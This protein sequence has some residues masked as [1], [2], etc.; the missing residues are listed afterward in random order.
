MTKVT[1][2]LC[3]SCQGESFS[4]SPRHWW[5]RI[6]YKSR[7][8]RCDD[9][10]TRIFVRRAKSHTWRS[11]YP[12]T[13]HSSQI[14]VYAPSR[15]RYLRAHRHRSGGRR[16]FDLKVVG[17]RDLTIVI[18][19]LQRGELLLNSLRHYLDLEPAPA[20]IIVIDQTRNHPESVAQELVRFTQASRI[21]WLSLRGRSHPAAMNLGLLYADTRYVVFQDD[22]V[23]P[24]RNL[25]GAFVTSIRELSRA[26]AGAFIA[27]QV[28]NVGEH[29]V[30]IQRQKG[31]F[32]LNSD[33]RYVVDNGGAGNLC[34]DRLAALEI[35]GFDENFVGNAY[36]ADTDLLWR[37]I[38]AG[39]EVVFEPRASVRHLRASTGGTRI[40]G[41]YV[42]NWRPHAA[43]CSYYFSLCWGR[44]PAGDP[45]PWLIP[46]RYLSTRSHLLRPWYI[47]RSLVSQTAALLWAIGLRIH[48]RKLVSCDHAELR[49]GEDRPATEYGSASAHR[50]AA[51]A[52]SGRK[53]Q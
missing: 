15:D 42:T 46:L 45:P 34:V 28:I 21:K 22:D 25:I 49:R 17:P 36:R 19:T 12:D 10:G 2:R 8:Y 18:P 48:G 40:F 37:A 13:P 7:A 50:S 44:M 20:N 51:Q 32:P 43:V 39:H 27:G 16:P 26:G 38:E 33:R 14:P 24:N 23:V 1:H 5:E 29:P 53:S 30:C 31:Q 3:A 47:P 4:R 35:G 41:H 11:Q 52:S 9:C 6:F